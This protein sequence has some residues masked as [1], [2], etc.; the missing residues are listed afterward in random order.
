M[1][2]LT[3]Q[4]TAIIVAGV[5]SSG[6]AIN[7]AASPATTSNDSTLQ[8]QV[9]QT[10]TSKSTTLAN[11]SST[12]SK[13]SGKTEYAVTPVVLLKQ[14][15]NLKVSNKKESLV[16]LV[17]VVVKPED[18]DRFKNIVVPEM[19]QSIKAESGILLMYALTDKNDPTIWY[20]FE[21]YKNQ[22]AYD[23]HQKQAVYKDY[24]AK[25]QNM[26]IDKKVYS[27]PA[28]VMDDDGNLNF[29]AK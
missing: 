13:L 16:N 12:D 27:V 1:N 22:A 14:E 17:R 26:I 25:T 2:T 10:T 5:I 6:L 11:N 8:N 20:L 3:K 23:H 24:L 19:Q 9:I 7:Q 15:R 28:N 29:N 4:L 18:N 21:I